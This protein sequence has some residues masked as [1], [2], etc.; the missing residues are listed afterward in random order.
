MSKR[1]QTTTSTTLD[2][3]SCT[4]LL[5]PTTPKT[6]VITL[7]ANNSTLTLLATRQPDPRME[8]VRSP[9][10]RAITNTVTASRGGGSDGSGPWNGV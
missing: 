7:R 6:S 2:T 1:K 4:G 9:R 3:P 10:R 5:E 8:S